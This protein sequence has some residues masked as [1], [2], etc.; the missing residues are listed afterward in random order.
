MCSLYH[1]FSVISRKSAFWLMSNFRMFFRSI[2]LHYYKLLISMQIILCFSFP[3]IY[4]HARAHTHTHVREH[5][6]C[7]LFALNWLLVDSF[8]IGISS[9]IYSLFAF[10]HFLSFSYLYNYPFHWMNA[11]KQIHS[12]FL[13]LSLWLT[14]WH[15]VG[16]LSTNLH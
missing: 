9:L 10:I 3:W 11:M 12:N 14:C 6:N 1:F 13:R 2:I 7:L 5:I 8:C 16:G 4:M 15:G